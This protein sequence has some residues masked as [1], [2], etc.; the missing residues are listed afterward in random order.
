[1]M[2]PDALELAARRLCKLRGLD[3]DELAAG[4]PRWQFMAARILRER[5]DMNDDRYTVR[6]DFDGQP[7][8]WD[9]YLAHVR[10]VAQRNAAIVI[11]T[12]ND[13]LAA[14]APPLDKP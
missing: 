13:M 9:A 1:M 6:V 4:F 2:N 5:Q 14:D 7:F 12:I 3:P 11:E 8:D 10:A